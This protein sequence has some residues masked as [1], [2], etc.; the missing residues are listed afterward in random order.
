MARSTPEAVQAI[1]DG[2]KWLGLAHD[3]GPF[4]QLK[5][6]DRYKQV[7]GE[8]LAVG[9][10]Y[11]CYMS[12]EELDA[13]PTGRLTSAERRRHFDT[14]KPGKGAGGHD[15]P[16]VLDEAEKTAVLEYLKTL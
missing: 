7:I 10:A 11:H 5:R 8:M 14:N 6:M 1:I 2:M 12:I 3:E 4:Y 15:F 16:D 9:T 13:L